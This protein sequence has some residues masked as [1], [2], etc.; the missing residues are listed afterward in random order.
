MS[1]YDEQQRRK[2][3][4][5]APRS[6]TVVKAAID[7]AKGAREAVVNEDLEPWSYEA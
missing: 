5:P 1:V 7:A 6:W 2:A 3:N 4:E